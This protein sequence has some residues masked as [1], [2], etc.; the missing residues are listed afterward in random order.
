M[1]FK[2]NI[3]VEFSYNDNTINTWSSITLNEPHISVSFYNF[4]LRNAQQA[5]VLSNYDFLSL[6]II[7]IEKVYVI[8]SLRIIKIP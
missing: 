4:S 2:N 3:R 7:K 1:Y 5:Q 8:F 6:I